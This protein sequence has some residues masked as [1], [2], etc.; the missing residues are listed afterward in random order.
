M[1]SPPD[2]TRRTVEDFHADL[3]AKVST[4]GNAT[5]IGVVLAAKVIAA[6]R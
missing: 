2:P 3:P 5:S 6:L 1:P 4:E